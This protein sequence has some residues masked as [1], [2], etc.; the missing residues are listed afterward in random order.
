MLSPRL[1]L[2]LRSLRLSPSARWLSCCRAA[3]AVAELFAAAAAGDTLRCCFFALLSC[4][5][6]LVLVLAV[7]E[8]FASRLLRSILCALPFSLL[9]PDPFLYHPALLE[10]N[11]CLL[12]PK[13]RGLS[14]ASFSFALPAA[15]FPMFV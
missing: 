1:R 2:L 8:V 3:V 4:P 13:D 5:P 6:P 14:Y 15:I 9:G 12:R 10:P 11:R 7:A